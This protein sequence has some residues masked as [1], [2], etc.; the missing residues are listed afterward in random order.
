MATQT[1]SQ[2]N[3]VAGKN[4]YHIDPLPLNGRLA[5]HSSAPRT[6]AKAGAWLDESKGWEAWL[7][8]L[9]SR[10]QPKPL[11]RLLPGKNSPLAWSAT[12]IGASSSLD[13]HLDILNRLCR[14]KSVSAAV[15]DAV[16]NDFLA[17]TDD[18]P[19]A[20]LECIAWTHALA[21]LAERTRAETWW[22]VFEKLLDK[23]LQAD[24]IKLEDTPLEHQFFAGE[25]RLT[26]AY[27][28]PEIKVT[29]G[30]VTPAR[31][32]LSE[33]PDFLLDGEGLPHA[34][35]L[36]LMRPLLA[37]WTRCM[38]MGQTMKHGCWNEPAE[39]QY[40]W[41]IRQAMR[42]TRRDGTQVLDHEGDDS[43]PAELFQAAM[44]VDGDRE[45]RAI[46]KLALP[47][48][49]KVASAKT[50]QKKKLP[51]SA[52]NSEW[53]ELAMLRPS[54]SHSE[55]LFA[56]DYSQ[57]ELK[58]ELSLGRHALLFG[59]A[60]L[61]LWI[62]D[63]RLEQQSDWES[64]CWESDKEVDYLELEASFSGDVR[65]QRQMLFAREDRL[66]F[67]ADAV[68]AKS[69]CDLRYSATWPLDSGTVAN[70]R[71]RTREVTLTAGKPRAEVL[72]LALSEWRRDS[73]LGEL[74][75]HQD[76]LQLEQSTTGAGLYAPLLIDM[77][78]RRR[79]RPT[80]W[81]QLTV[82]EDRKILTSDVAVG[83]RVQV[84][85]KQWLIYR[86]IGERGNRT[87]LGENTISEFMMCRFDAGGAGDQLIEIE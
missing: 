43:W 2:K 36:P 34:A 48:V 44:E 79:G 70:P 65:V 53:A 10:L 74:H 75:A 69:P 60:K 38:A 17:S 51:P 56:V 78:P 63:D 20:A 77:D 42:F 6:V 52:T 55:G 16:V 41:I 76:C 58:V 46:A 7:E 86:S 80:T 24:D 3:S 12:R 1:S 59:S 4:G 62:D 81:R 23:A 50:R 71:K 30:L 39:I 13:E 54:W 82:A 83:Y 68:L 22:K 27:N 85:K 66:L 47:P 37:C 87:V 5:W 40:A 19:A 29:R 31:R 28:F 57:P 45:D 9:G 49:K 64:V 18:S 21:P 15:L 8:H 84:G 25:L 61:D 14:G 73:R 33:G 32:A 67:L 35:L 26:L 11:S 72:P